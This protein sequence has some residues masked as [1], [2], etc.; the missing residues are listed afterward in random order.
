MSFQNPGAE[1]FQE[2]KGE[3]LSFLVVWKKKSPRHGGEM[4]WKKTESKNSWTLFFLQTISP[5]CLG[6][7]FF[8]CTK[9]A[10]ALDTPSCYFSEPG[11]WILTRGG[12]N[13]PVISW[14][15][16]RKKYS[17]VPIIGSFYWVSPRVLGLC[18]F[19]TISPQAPKLASAL[20][21]PSAAFQ[22]QGSGY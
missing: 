10:S 20:D 13:N 18:F 8:Q 1:K 6:L 4:V 11:F 19:H 2:Q 12:S 16:G 9:T 5:P 17:A 7:C 21:Y 15:P 3:N 14:K 22:H